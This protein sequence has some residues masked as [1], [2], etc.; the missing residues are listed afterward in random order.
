MATQCRTLKG[1]LEGNG[2]REFFLYVGGN[3]GNY[4][5]S[6]VNTHFPTI[7]N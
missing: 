1:H 3:V 4:E 6:I 5:S 7:N 2:W